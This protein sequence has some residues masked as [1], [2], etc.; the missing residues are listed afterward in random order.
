M[1]GVPADTARVRAFVGELEMP[2]ESI[3]QNSEDER[4]GIVHAL[5]PKIPARGQ[6]D[7]KV[8]VE[9]GGIWQAVYLRGGLQVDEAIFFDS[10]AP[11]WGP[12]AGGTRVVIQGRGFE[13]GNTVTDGCLLYTSPSPRDRG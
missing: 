9:K 1:L 6:Y 7:I 3:E 10:L 5:T 12:L 11:Q 13:P 2:I 8:L 4:I